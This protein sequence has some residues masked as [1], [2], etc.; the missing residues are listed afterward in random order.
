MNTRTRLFG[1]LAALSL[2][3]PVLAACG[4]SSGSD[5]ASADGGKLIVATTVAP[6]TSIAAAVGGDK[7]VIKGIVPEGTNSHTFEPA[8]KVAETLSEAD[9][10]FVNGLQ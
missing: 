9:I 7:V 10:V 6:I 1:S 3:L 2:T 8:P 4:D 5:S